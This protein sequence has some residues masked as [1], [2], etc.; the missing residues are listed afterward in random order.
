[1]T[2]DFYGEYYEGLVRV[3]ELMLREI[4]V[5]IDSLG[6]D[7]ETT[8][9]EHIKSRIK[10]PASLCEKLER[11]G[12]P[13]SAESGLRELSDV[14]GVRVVTHFIGD[15]Y[16]VLGLIERD[17]NWSVFRR[18]LARNCGGG[19]LIT[20]QGG[21]FLYGFYFVVAPDVDKLNKFYWK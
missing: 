18:G 9:A 4:G 13:V 11:L 20:S 5:M 10:S 19:K 8:P 3:E 16:T 1:M 15:I 2:N 14:I 12:L 6:A 17:P 21:R 7:S